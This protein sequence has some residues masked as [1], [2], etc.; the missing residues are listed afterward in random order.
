MPNAMQENAN[1]PPFYDN[2]PAVQPGQAGSFQQI[3][4]RVTPPDQQTGAA[5]APTDDTETSRSGR[6][7]RLKWA[8]ARLLF[9]A[10][11]GFAL[12]SLV[13]G[14]LSAPLMTKLF[15]GDWRFWRHWR[16]GWRLLPHG[17][18]ILWMTMRRQGQF[19]FSVPL[20]SPPQS[21]PDRDR[22]R[23]SPQWRH[24]GSC[25]DCQRCCRVMELDCPVLDPGTGFCS[26]Y[27]SFYWRY[28]NCGRYPSRQFEIDYYG[29]DK[30]L[31]HDE[32]LRALSPVF[33]TNL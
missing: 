19:M 25:G 14:F 8:G 9:Y 20:T 28:F 22:V 5:P 15:F 21:V 16:R 18:V 32:G 24:G 31:I 12:F 7:S 17:G 33:E 3:P 1:C 4:I 30:W 23:L 6:L 27:D 13:G 11:I 2:E 26:G 29:C 10:Y